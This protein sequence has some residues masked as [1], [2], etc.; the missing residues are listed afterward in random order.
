[1]SSSA[2]D[3]DA[4]QTLVSSLSSGSS[5]EQ[6]NSILACPALTSVHKDSASKAR[7][8]LLRGRLHLLHP[9]PTIR[10]QALDALSAAVKFDL[11]NASAWVT[12]GNA[13]LELTRDK[14]A[15]L[16]CYDRVIDAYRSTSS[17]SNS[18]TSNSAL[19]KQSYKDALRQKARVLTSAPL[20]KEAVALD[21]KDPESWY[22]L[23]TAL[24]AHMELDG[25]LRA[26]S[27]AEKQ[28]LGD[29]PELHY[30]KG[31]IHMYLEQYDAAVAAFK[32]SGLPRCD[33]MVGECVQRVKQTVRAMQRVQSGAQF[34]EFSGKGMVEV[35]VSASDATPLTAIIS[36]DGSASYSVV[37]VYNTGPVALRPGLAI[38]VPAS[39]IRHVRVSLDDAQYT[40]SQIFDITQVRVGGRRLSV[41]PPRTAIKR[42]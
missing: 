18:S 19:D 5:A 1:M 35:V 26:Y 2:L 24:L 27:Q 36:N 41:L 20:A 39:A 14:D 31:I 22:V 12:L 15:A 8:S 3:L 23:G 33:D 17:T 29:A 10:S 32:R 37:S 30:N 40:C 25:A 28:G 38:E 16:Q 13:H 21:I 6:I 9:D 34:V 7:A 4:L 11:S 42:Q